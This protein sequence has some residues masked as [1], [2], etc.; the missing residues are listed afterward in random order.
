MTSGHDHAA[1]EKGDERC[2][3]CSFWGIR[4]F[5]D[6]GIQWGYWCCSL[7]PVVS[8]HSP[9]RN[10]PQLL[11]RPV[12][13]IERATRGSL[14]LYLIHPCKSHASTDYTTKEGTLE[15]RDDASMLYTT[16][17]FRKRYSRQSVTHV[18]IRPLVCQCK[19]C[20]VY[21]LW[22]YIA[23]LAHWFGKANLLHSSHARHARSEGW[24]GWG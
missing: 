6:P 20:S 15:A 21:D 18:T 11:F 10:G 22:G 9:A 13:S 17:S 24:P 12:S 16:A 19:A 7:R 8:E 2:G 4:S 14:H 23:L 1:K 3:R 5:P